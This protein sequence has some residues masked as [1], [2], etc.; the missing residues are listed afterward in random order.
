MAIEVLF[1]SKND[2]PR[3][4][5]KFQSN[6]RSHGT[7]SVSQS[8]GHETFTATNRA[9]SRER[10]GSSNPPESVEFWARLW[11]NGLRRPTETSGCLVAKATCA[12]RPS[13][14]LHPSNTLVGWRCRKRRD[15][16]LQLHS[17]SFTF[18]FRLAMGTNLASVL[19]DRCHPE[20]EIVPL[21]VPGALLLP[22]CLY[23]VRIRHC[24]SLSQHRSF[25][26]N[27][28]NSHLP[29]DSSRGLMVS[30]PKPM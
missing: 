1:V 16:P 5:G 19:G 26:A 14:A 25:V 12:P 22:V 4:G 11:P 27:I 17:T 28:Q 7:K 29:E 20:Y 6:P 30:N 24:K 21:T 15:G 13:V 23:P 10:F 3:A 18:I 8:S 9:A 2:S